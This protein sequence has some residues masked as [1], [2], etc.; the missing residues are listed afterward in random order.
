MK[1]IDYQLELERRAYL[2]T[3]NPMRVWNAYGVARQ[4]Q[5]AIPEWVLQYLD[6]ARLGLV[7]NVQDTIEEQGTKTNLAPVIARAFGMTSRGSGSPLDFDMDWWR[8]GL[9]LRSFLDRGDQLDHARRFA[10]EEF[11]VHPSTIIRSAKLFDKVCPAGDEQFKID[12]DDLPDDEVVIHEDET[13]VDPDIPRSLP[14][15]DE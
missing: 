12:E 11:G 4:S 6:K 7:F 9:T 1:R 13:Y 3:K 2:V 15:D 14:F 10:A 5:R 8:H